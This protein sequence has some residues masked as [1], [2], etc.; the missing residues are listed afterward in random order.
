MCSQAAA[1]SVHAQGTAFLMQQQQSY[2]QVCTRIRSRLSLS[3]R[4]GTYR[5]QMGIGI[6]EGSSLYQENIIRGM[7]EPG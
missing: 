7:H 2:I 3:L 5:L 6:A 1:C 4:A